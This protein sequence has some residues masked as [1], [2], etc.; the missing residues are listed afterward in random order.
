MSATLCFPTMRYIFFIF[1]FIAAF[2][3]MFTKKLEVVGIAIFF[4]VNLI[5]T[6]SIGMDL[7]SYVSTHARNLS[8]ADK[9][10]SLSIIICFVLNLASS[11]FLLITMNGLRKKFMDAGGNEILLSDENRS[12]L[13]QIEQL[14]LCLSIFT[15]VIGINV[16][17]ETI[18]KIRYLADNIGKY[19][20]P[21]TGPFYLISLFLIFILLCTLAGLLNSQNNTDFTFNEFKSKIMAMLGILIMILVYFPMKYFISGSNPTTPLF[22]YASMF[23]V[24]LIVL[25]LVGIEYQTFANSQ[26]TDTN[27]PYETDGSGNPITINNLKA[28]ERQQRIETRI[29]KS[30]KVAA[31]LFY[32]VFVIILVMVLAGGFVR[33]FLPNIADST[34][35]FIKA[36]LFL[37]ATDFH[38][39]ISKFMIILLFLVYFIKSCISFDNL[40]TSANPLSNT[41]NFVFIGLSVLMCIFLIINVLNAKTFSKVIVWSIKY[42]LPIISVALSGYLMYATYTMSLLYKHEITQ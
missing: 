15:F 10:S 30:N 1:L 7:I 41:I 37:F 25:V 42:V 24:I 32:G 12:K 16:Y 20:L 39:V 38:M 23:I 4:I 18:K 26:Y 9:G 36:I 6:I 40:Y 3:L 17:F 31:G 29:M 19:I 2:G 13:T 27:K 5:F 21:R 34:P 22:S 14:F 28:G 35:P 8:I 33:T 11:M